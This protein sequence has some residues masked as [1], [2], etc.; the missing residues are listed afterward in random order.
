MCL[1]DEET[2]LHV[3]TLGSEIYSVDFKPALKQVGAPQLLIDG[4]YSPCLKDTNEVW[5]LAVFK[6]VGDNRYVTVSDDGYLMIWDATKKTSQ[7]KL[8]LTL[9]P[10]GQPYPLDAATGELS[11][12]VKARSIDISSD[13]ELVAIGFRDGS[14]AV[15]ATDDWTLLKKFLV[16]DNKQSPLV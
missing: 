11:N 5:G 9:D 12:S 13:G 1:N 3:G 6:A 15:Y 4:H 14:V 2:K 8:N 16:T 10:N 7:F